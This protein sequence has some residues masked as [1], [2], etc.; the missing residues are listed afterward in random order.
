VVDGRA[1]VR[2]VDHL[3][4]TPP[5][6]AADVVVIELGAGSWMAVRPS[7]T[8]PKLKVYAEVVEPVSEGQ[9]AAARTRAAASLAGLHA[10]MATHLGFPFG[11][12][13]LG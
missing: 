7:G 13:T 2:V 11:G 12:P 3:A 5:E 9:V 4:P 1:V 8:E 6:P 10:A